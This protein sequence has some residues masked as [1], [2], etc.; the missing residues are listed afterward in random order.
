MKR[1]DLCCNFLEKLADDDTTMNKL[2]FSDE[3]T[4]RLSGQVNR[5]NLRNWGS[6]NP[7]ESLEHERD[8]AKLNVFAAVSRENLYGPFFFI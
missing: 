1:C 8:R 7:H 2:V 3:A 4:F 6:G 5:H